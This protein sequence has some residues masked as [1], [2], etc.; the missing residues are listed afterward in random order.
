M[1]IQLAV[2]SQWPFLLQHCSHGGTVTEV[3]TYWT[4]PV[5][6]VDFILLLPYL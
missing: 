1:M 6:P 3:Q 5:L 4:I 2:V